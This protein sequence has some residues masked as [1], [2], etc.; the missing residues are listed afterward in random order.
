[1][2]ILHGQ[3]MRSLARHRVAAFVGEL[4]PGGRA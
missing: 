1:M 2:V 3:A 4:I